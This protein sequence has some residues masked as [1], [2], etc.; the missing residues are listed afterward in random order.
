[1]N[2]FFALFSLLKKKENQHRFFC[3]VF[4]VSLHMFLFF[5]KFWIGKEMALFSVQAE[6]LNHLGDA[7][8]NFLFLLVLLYAQLPADQHHPYGHAR[9][10]Y[11]SG[12]AL[13]SLMFF[14]GGHLLW[15]SLQKFF[16]FGLQTPVELSSFALGFLLLSLLI[17]VFLFFFYGF[18]SKKWQSVSIK[19]AAEDSKIDLLQ[20]SVVLLSLIFQ[21]FL[22]F[23][24]DFPLSLV[25]AFY[26]LRQAS[27]LWFELLSSLLGKGWSEE[28]KEK[29]VQKI[30]SYPQVK[31]CHDFM[32]HRY[33][34][35]KIYASCH[36]ELP[37]HL[38]FQEAHDIADQIEHDFWHQ[39]KVE[40]LLH[41]DL[42]LDAKQDLFALSK[43]IQLFL[44]RKLSLYSLHDLHK[45]G[46]EGERIDFELMLPYED[47]TDEISLKKELQTFLNE[48]FPQK[49]FHFFIERGICK[50]TDK[51]S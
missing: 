41:L 14:L 33:G 50:K 31:G 23:S 51:V 36:I 18:L 49:N 48:E 7:L 38:S 28:E 22:S 46:L 13:A 6:A 21:R 5:G 30:L 4:I 17:K 44:D 34:P 3:I 39:K 11:L 16:F 19:M 29:S 15:E 32:L 1:M 2:D 27:K 9:I 26:T 47:K 12:I 10:E 45:V 8:H 37:A 40:L 25:L 42:A 35:D 24:L 43:K 20:N